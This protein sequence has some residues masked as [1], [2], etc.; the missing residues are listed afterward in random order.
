MGPRRT[1]SARWTDF[2]RRCLAPRIPRLAV[3]PATVTFCC[4]EGGSDA[5]GAL[6]AEIA[7]VAASHRPWLLRRVPERC[8]R[9]L[10]DLR[11]M[12]V[13][14]RLDGLSPVPAPGDT[15]RLYQSCNCAL[16]KVT[17]KWIILRMCRHSDYLLAGVRY[18]IMRWASSWT[19]AGRAEARSFS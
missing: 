17:V 8:P 3:T 15:C 9:A 16:I 4:W 7:G 12:A 6:G 2:A 14:S 19:T 18:C 5:F 1:R 11:W 13:E 10:T